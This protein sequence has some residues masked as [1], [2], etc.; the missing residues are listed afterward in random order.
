MFGRHHCAAAKSCSL[1]LANR[2]TASL[3]SYWPSAN[4]PGGNSHSHTVRVRS[5]ATGSNLRTITWSLINDRKQFG[6]STMP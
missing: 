5:T 1:T 2:A 6:R 3:T 4:V